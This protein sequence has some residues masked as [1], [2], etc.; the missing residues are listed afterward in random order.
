MFGTISM[1]QNALTLELGLQVEWAKV[2]DDLKGQ[3]YFV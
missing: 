2:S 3:M 1:M